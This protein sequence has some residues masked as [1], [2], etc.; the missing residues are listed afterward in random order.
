MT[1]PPNTIPPELLSA[2]TLN[3]SIGVEEWYVNSSYASDKHR[4]Y[5]KKDIA[6]YCADIKAK[7]TSYY[8]KTDMWLYRA[9]QKYPIHGLEVV[10]MG[11]TTP[12]Y[13]SVC[14]TFGGMPTTIEYNALATDEPNLKILTVEEFWRAPRQFDAAF[15]ISSFEHDGLG[16]YGDP[17]NPNGDLEAMKKM[18]KILKMDGL[19]FLV[20]PVGKDKLV[21]NAHR[22]YGYKRL[23]RLLNGWKVIDRFGYNPLRCW[24]DNGKDAG[25]Q[26]LF[27]LKNTKCELFN[28]LSKTT[29]D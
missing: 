4:F 6:G 19:L 29:R 16:R 14:L 28:Q 17:L 24:M 20:V 26:P 22:I 11:S 8:G 18:K 10:I 25:Y 13:E 23:P 3:G 21:W 2:Y 7:K 15:S 27:V 1:E 12:W 5:S 9:L